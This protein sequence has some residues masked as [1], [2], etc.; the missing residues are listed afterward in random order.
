MR[1]S[2]A[3]AAVAVLALIAAAPAAHAEPSTSIGRGGAA[4]TVDRPATEAATE[5][6]RR[7]G[8]ATDAAVTAAAVLA[9][10]EPFSCGIGGG[11]FMVSYDAR[12]RGVSTLD[13]RERAPQAMGPDS[14]FENGAPLA[15]NDARYSGLSVG[16]P[17]TVLG[18]SRALRKDGTISLAQALAPAIRIARKGFVVDAA[19]AAQT[20]ENLD[21]FDDVPATAALYLDPDGTP[22]DVGTVLR[23]PDLARTFELIA[24]RG[25]R[26]FYY[27]PVA[28]AIVS[29]VRNP[30]VGPTANHA[31][32]P[33]MMTAGDLRDYSAPRR[34]PV[35]SSYR[36][37]DVF[38][39]GPPSSGGTTIA[40]ALNIL[41]GYD[42]DKMPRGDALHLEL[43]AARLAFADRGAYVADPAYHDVP[44]T[45]L[46]SKPFAATRRA[47]IG[48]RAL[49]SPV[50]PGDPRP[51]GGGGAGEAS[52]TSTRAGTTTHITVADRRGDVVSYTFTIESTG[53]A[54]LVVPGYGFLL[55]NE[56]TD[57]NFNS[58]THPNRVEGGKRPRSS[59]APTIVLRDGRPWLALGS[60][61]GSTIITTVLGL[62]VDRVDLGRTLPA[63]I[64]APRASQRDTP[65]TTAEPAFIGSPE[66][67]A[68]HA[69][70]HAFTPSPEIGAATGIEFLGHGRLLAAAEPVR[71]GGGS[72]LVAQPSK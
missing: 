24:K 21:Y 68:L 59:M 15:F 7:G 30:P 72:A 26:A 64:A 65:A 13:H 60:P 34:A 62:L 9:V 49:T 29:T 66:A 61:G 37:L 27:G 51:Y 31:Y 4:T 47:L 8:N 41:E 67:A 56:L 22:R 70:G 6:L 16:V 58:K 33:G 40:E 71:R 5:V 38:G 43:E 32:R 46:I 53:G 44:L 54:G 42:L 69:R 12:D 55:N 28:E 19:F 1:F 50:A 48:P 11:G 36:G 52:L 18:W 63:A 45:G 20:Q 14:F 23:N 10:T 39:M 25:A 35:R 17:G 2:F 57:F 3:A